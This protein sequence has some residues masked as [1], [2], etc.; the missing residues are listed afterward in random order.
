MPK[1]SDENEEK[2]NTK[3]LEVWV[4]PVVKIKKVDTTKT[5]SLYFDSVIDDVEDLITRGQYT[6]QQIADYYGCNLTQFF[7]WKRDSK[8]K[9]RI[10]EAMEFRAY[11]LADMANQILLEGFGENSVPQA[12]LRNQLSK[13][14]NWQ[15]ARMNPKRF[16][17]KKQEDINISMN[18]LPMTGEQFDKLLEDAVVRRQEEMVDTP[19]YE[20]LEEVEDEKNGEVDWEKLEKDTDENI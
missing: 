9:E 20:E 8:H 2:K 15:A 7:R 10:E 11:Q 4:P 19:E 13:N 14:Y 12:M 18:H 6:F 17:D 5:W 3:E 16:G 1:K